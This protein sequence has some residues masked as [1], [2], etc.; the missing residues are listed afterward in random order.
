MNT[1]NERKLFL[2]KAAECLEILCSR[3]NWQVEKKQSFSN[4]K[5]ELS[6]FTDLV[7]G[8]SLNDLNTFNE[9]IKEHARVTCFFASAYEKGCKIEIVVRFNP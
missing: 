5:Y 7:A 3:T 1:E 6:I 4:E 2:L 8:I 9:T